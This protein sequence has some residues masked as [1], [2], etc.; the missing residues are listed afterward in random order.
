MHRDHG[1]FARA[2]ERQKKVKL[3]F[4]S[5]KQRRNMVRPAA[6][7]HYSEGMGAG[8]D[9]DCYYFWDFEAPKG[10]NFLALPP[11]QIIIMEPTEDIFRLDEFS[12]LSKM[13]GDSTTT[14]SASSNEQG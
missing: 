5:R 6:P 8:D 3:T 11:S 10:S 13:M 9:T 1:I 7:L 14:G 4:Y 2:V 12:S